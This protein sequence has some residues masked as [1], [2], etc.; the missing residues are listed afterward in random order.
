MCV[1]LLPLLISCNEY[2]AVVLAAAA[3]AVAVVAAA[4]VAAAVVCVP[5][6]LQIKTRAAEL[7]LGGCP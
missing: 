4:A 2:V 5:R 1:L 6:P 3:V 7:P